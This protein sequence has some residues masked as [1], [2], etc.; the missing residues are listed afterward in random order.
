[1]H[2]V[3]PVLLAGGTGTRLWPLSRKSYP[4]QFSKLTGNHSLFQQ[5]AERC[6][7]SAHMTFSEPLIMTNNEFRFIVAEQL[8]RIGIGNYSIMIEPKPKNTGSAI[9]AAAMHIARDD[10]DTLCLATPTDHILKDR[11]QFHKAIQSGLEGL[12]KRTIV[13]FGVKPTRAET[14][15]GYIEFESK[16][17]DHAIKVKRFIEK[18][19]SQV[20][21]EMILS[22]KFLWNMGIFLFRAGDMIEQFNLHYRALLKPAEDAIL[23]SHED[24]DF[25]RLDSAAWEKMADISIDFAI[26]EKSKNLVAVPYHGEWTDM[27][28]WES[29]WEQE[30]ISADGLVLSGNASAINCSNSLLR[31]EGSGQH[32]VGVGLKNILAIAMNDAVLVADK[33]SSQ[34]IRDV[35]PL[36]KS[37]GINQAEIFPTDYRPWGWF[38]VLIEQKNFKVKRILVYPKAALSLQSHEHR[39]EH[40]VVVEGRALISLD[41]KEFVL[42]HSQS[43][44]IPIGSKHRLTN[45]EDVPL[46]IIEIQMGSYLG[47]DDIVRYEDKYKR[48]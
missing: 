37:K 47:E 8:R 22:E 40:W 38:E 15:Y 18:P 34:S 33:D 25:I 11:M 36:L 5:S 29:V 26:M 44:S 9:L 2:K 1:M 10:P 31:S 12:E 30:N 42:S 14:G 7:S 39:S 32:I 4:K 19:S 23:N 21:E 13:T 6:V 17:A 35:I 45:V 20:A 16:T 27:G 43:I 41:S 28:T 3:T 48:E 46:E 24:L